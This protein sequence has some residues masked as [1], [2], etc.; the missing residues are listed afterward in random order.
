MI[1]L[2]LVHFGHFDFSLTPCLYFQTTADA[3]RLPV[4]E[5]NLPKIPCQPISAQDAWNFIR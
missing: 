4:S 1:L 5:A 2:C 3:Y